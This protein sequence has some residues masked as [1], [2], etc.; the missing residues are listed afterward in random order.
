MVLAYRVWL[1]FIGNPAISIANGRSM[2]GDFV[3][4]KQASA[5]LF[6][7]HEVAE[8][9]QFVGLT[10]YFPFGGGIWGYVG[11]TTLIN[12]NNGEPG[13][14]HILKLAKPVLLPPRQGQK[15]IADI[16]PMND[17]FLTSLNNATGEC[18]IKFM[19]DGLHSRD[20]L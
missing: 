7:T 14:D 13:Q 15:V 20:V 18:D 4:Y 19:E 12:M 2:N 5:Q 11:D 1:F 16:I 3:L 17:S 6:W 9:A 8:K 10:C